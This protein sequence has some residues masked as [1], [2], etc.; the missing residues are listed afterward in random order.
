MDATQR[1]KETS[2]DKMS[3][4]K[5]GWENRD[6]CKAIGGTMGSPVCTTERSCEH[7]Q[8]EPEKRP[9]VCPVCGK[10]LQYGV[11]I[12]AACSQDWHCECGWTQ[13][14]SDQRPPMP[15]ARDGYHAGEWREIKVGDFWFSPEGRLFGPANHIDTHNTER[16]IAVLDAKPLIGNT[17]I[18]DKCKRVPA[19]CTCKDAKASEPVVRYWKGLDT[20]IKFLVRSVDGIVVEVYPS[21]CE[22]WKGQPWDDRETSLWHE[23]SFDEYNNALQATTAKQ[24]VKTVEPLELLMLK[25]RNAIAD[26]EFVTAQA[27]KELD[28]G[29]WT[30][31]WAHEQVVQ[32]SVIDG[33]IEKIERLAKVGVRQ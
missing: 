8:A 17:K 31:D 12:V 4:S 21:V 2:E 33:L 11:A 1:D 32:Q 19:A 13:P 6:L 29:G 10:T 16:W 30:C 26:K 15:A 24:P 7:R 25:L 3:E 9:L 18:C 27:N 23:V 22:A 14:D 20:F 28:R 5:C